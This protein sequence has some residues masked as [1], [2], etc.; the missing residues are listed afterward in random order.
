[1]KDTGFIV[2]IWNSR[3]KCWK[4][5]LA[6]HIGPAVLYI[7]RDATKLARELREALNAKTKVGRCIL[8]CL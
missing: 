7:R 8:S 3:R 1:M 6:N 2:L 5:A 4:P